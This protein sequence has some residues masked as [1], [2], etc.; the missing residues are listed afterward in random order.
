MREHEWRVNVMDADGK[1]VG[2]TERIF[3]MGE[4]G[5]GRR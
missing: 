4:A 5:A 1:V 3:R 2:H